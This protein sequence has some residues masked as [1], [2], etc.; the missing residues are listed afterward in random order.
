MVK[1]D[2]IQYDVQAAVKRA[3]E[4]EWTFDQWAI[5]SGVS[6]FTIRKW[7]YGDPTIKFASVDKIV[8]PLGLR[9]V[10]LIRTNGKKK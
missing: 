9:A 10:D 2:H 6:A 7:I 4:R 3:E 1:E 5:E 8:R